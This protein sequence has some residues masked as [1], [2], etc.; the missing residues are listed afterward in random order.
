MKLVSI[1]IE[2]ELAFFK[3]PQFNGEIDS[4]NYSFES[5][6]RPALLGMFGSLLGLG[7]IKDDGLEGSVFPEYY[8]LLGDISIS[9]SILTDIRKQKITINSHNGLFSKEPGGVLNL[10]YDM[11]IKPKYRIYVLLDMGNQYH[12]D[13]YNILKNNLCGYFGEIYMGKSF[14]VAT[15]SNFR[16][17]TYEKINEYEGIVASLF[18]GEYE[19]M[20]DDYGNI[21]EHS[22]YVMSFLFETYN[23]DILHE[24]HISLPLGLERI[25]NTDEIRYSKFIEYKNTNKNILIKS[26]NLY[27]LN[28]GDVVYM[29]C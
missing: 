25:D 16:E 19:Y 23:D 4:M 28:N 17:Y 2:S 12:A 13:L 5:I 22:E 21:D 9:I 15:R 26:T 7:G 20:E 6:H 24:R 14:C 27:K 1:D 29:M 18:L 3:N 8:D 11:L 10:H